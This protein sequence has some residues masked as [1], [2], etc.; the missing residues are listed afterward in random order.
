MSPSARIKSI[1]TLGDWKGYLKCFVSEVWDLLCSVDRKV[2][3]TED[4]LQERVSYWRHE[5][6]QSEQEVWEAKKALECCEDDKDNDCTDEEEALHEAR[7]L[8]R[9]AEEELGNVRSWKQRVDEIVVAYRL[10]AERLRRLL[11]ADMPRADA[12]L[13]RAINDLHKYITEISLAEQTGLSDSVSPSVSNSTSARGSTSWAIEDRQLQSAWETLFASEKGKA[14]AENIRR[15]S[16][17]VKFGYLP[18]DEKG[19]PGEIG[20]YYPD[21]NEI[22]IRLDQKYRSTK[23]LAAHLA[24]EGIH[25][26]WDKPNSVDQEYDA[27]KAQCEVWM[28]LKGNDSDEN[29]EEVCELISLGEDGAKDVIS[30]IRPNLPNTA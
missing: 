26:L 24:H 27:F 2:K 8:L 11:T 23:V 1:E 18:E 17:K 20:R 28:E 15:K 29:C 16:I 19:N 14:I 6:E 3:N 5:V 9:N 22:V 10:Q 7:R 21:E 30:H 13:G 4:W 25:V 12:F